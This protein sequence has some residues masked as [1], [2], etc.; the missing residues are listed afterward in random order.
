[1]CF[2]LSPPDG[3]ACVA[4][5]STTKMNP[6]NP[7]APWVWHSFIGSRFSTG[8]SG[9]SSV[10]HNEGGG[11]KKI[12]DSTVHKR[13]HLIWQFNQLNP[14]SSEA[15]WNLSVITDKSPASLLTL[16][17]GGFIR[18]RK[19]KSAMGAWSYPHGTLKKKITTMNKL[20]G[21]KYTELAVLLTELL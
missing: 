17:K 4:T 1:M 3:A 2:Y 19:R 6:G 7:P 16:G 13:K 18:R 9:V 21:K 14:A 15:W 10:R 11:R 12:T 5:V 8:K 20:R